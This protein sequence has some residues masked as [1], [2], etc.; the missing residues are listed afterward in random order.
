MATPINISG[1]LSQLQVLAQQAAKDFVAGNIN[2]VKDLGEQEGQQFLNALFHATLIDKLQ[3][4]MPLGDNPSADDIA[5]QEDLI[6]ARDTQL[7]LVYAGEA[8][9]ASDKQ[10]LRDG[11]LK[12]VTALLGS[13]GSVVAKIF[14]GGL[15]AL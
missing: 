4:V 13:V 15:S 1:S 5:D 14:T 2:V 9:I 8:K 7:A 12:A 3:A 11:A 6:A 10:S